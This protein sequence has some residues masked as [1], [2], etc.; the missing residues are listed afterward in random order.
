MVSINMEGKLFTHVHL[1]ESYRTS[2]IHLNTQIVNIS[3]IEDGT[4][5]RFPNGDS[6]SQ[7][8]KFLD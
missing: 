1:I 5:Y 2:M 7:K 8:L 6:D 3:P 4:V